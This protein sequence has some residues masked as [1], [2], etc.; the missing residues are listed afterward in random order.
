MTAYAFK[1][2]QDMKEPNRPFE[3]IMLNEPISDKARNFDAM[4]LSYYR[5][6]MDV[7]KEKVN[8]TRANNRINELMS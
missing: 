7:L 6:R 8:L 4:E 3:E 1:T 5:D 2:N